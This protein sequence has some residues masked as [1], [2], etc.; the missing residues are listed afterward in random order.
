MPKAKE[1]LEKAYGSIPK[2]V[3]FYFEFP[4]RG[5]KYYWLRLIRRI[6]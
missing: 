1:V 3:G 5:L 6:R 2:E 4:F